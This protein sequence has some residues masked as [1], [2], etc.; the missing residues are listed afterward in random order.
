MRGITV[1]KIR[2]KKTGGSIGKERRYGDYFVTNN[3]A[4]SRS[5]ADIVTR[6]NRYFVIDLNSKNHTYI[7]DRELPIHYETEIIDGDRLR[8]GNEEVVF[9]I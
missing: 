8:L 7:N 1:E 5:H 2:V 6:G 4:V 9:T 3:I